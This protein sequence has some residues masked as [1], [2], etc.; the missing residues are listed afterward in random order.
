M[1][2][3]CVFIPYLKRFDVIRLPSSI[4][5]IIIVSC[6]IFVEIALKKNSFRVYRQLQK[7]TQKNHIKLRFKTIHAT[8]LIMFARGANKKDYLSIELFRGKIRLVRMNILNKSLL[9]FSLFPKPR[10]RPKKY[11]DYY[12]G[13]VVIYER[14]C[15]SRAI[16]L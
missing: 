8:G 7:T 14:P 15:L 10:K 9:I 12:Q 3:F 13:L 11:L 2:E 5:K 6:L 4:Y 1:Y 16:I